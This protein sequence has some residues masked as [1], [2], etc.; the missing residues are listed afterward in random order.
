MEIILDGRQ[1]PYGLGI[2]NSNDD[3][4]RILSMDQSS[5]ILSLQIFNDCLGL[6]H[7]LPSLHCHIKEQMWDNSE[8]YKSFAEHAALVM[9]CNV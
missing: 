9:S 2:T 8:I 6:I 5:T 7:K 1:Y 4:E 3:L